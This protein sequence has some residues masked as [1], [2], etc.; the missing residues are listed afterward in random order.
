MSA[1]GNRL[2]RVQELIRTRSTHPDVAQ[3]LAQF[4]HTEGASVPLLVKHHGFDRRRVLEI[5]SSFGQNLLFW[6]PG[7]EGVEGDESSVA[8]TTE[9]GFPAHRLNVE[10]D[11]FSRLPVASYDAIHSR[12]V[13]E[14]LIAPH[15]FLARLH[16]LLVPGGLLALGHPIVPQGRLAPVLLDRLGVRGWLSVTHINFFT[17]ATIRLMLERA[18]FRVKAQYSPRLSQVSPLL[19]RLLLPYG[20]S[21]LSICEKVEGYTYHPKRTPEFDPGWA[22]EALA[23]YHQP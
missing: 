23:P 9:L 1:A 21:V 4:F 11:A 20:P 2:E 10:E 18:G 5:G 6:G 16:R 3:I 15:L 12:D 13:I 17:P 14:H 22:R 19:G 7:S 8:F